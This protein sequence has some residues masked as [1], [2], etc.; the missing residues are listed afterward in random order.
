MADKGLYLAH[1]HTTFLN[2]SDSSIRKQ[3]DKF[4]IKT[5]NCWVFNKE[6]PLKLRD[7]NSLLYREHERQH[8]VQALSTPVGLYL[9]RCLLT[10][11]SCIQYILDV[12]HN[13]STVEIEDLPLTEWYLKGGIIIIE[14]A[15]LNEP[16]YAI[17]IN[18]LFGY[19]EVLTKFIQALEDGRCLSMKEFI[20]LANSANEEIKRA[21]DMPISY[22]WCSHTES[23][24]DYLPAGLFTITEIMEAGAR[25]KERSL[26]FQARNGQE[27]V[28]EWEASTIH[29]IYAPA[30][31]WLLESLDHPDAAALAIDLSL[32]TPI[33]LC[34]VSLLDGKLYVEDCHPGWR[35]PR[36][37]KAMQN[38]FWRSDG[39]ENLN[40]M[41]SEVMLKAGLGSVRSIAMH[42]QSAPFNGPNSWGADGRARGL[43]EELRIDN[44]IQFIEQEL[45][46]NIGSRAVTPFSGAFSGVMG[47]PMI[48]FPIEFYSDTA[49]MNNTP[50]IAQFGNPKIAFKM[51]D[52]TIGNLSLLAMIQDGSVELIKNVENSFRK[53]LVNDYKL[54]W[55]KF[56]HLHAYEIARAHCGRFADL[57]EWE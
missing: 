6:I 18:R 10:L 35:L 31:R 28:R 2:V 29:G 49:T 39:P 22:E 53:M 32:M 26:L 52:Y 21:S 34:T 4:T 51:Y 9:W 43:P 8:H 44:Y 47:T 38:V 20:A 48:R 41:I 55:N 19:I 3:L 40:E 25:L 37:V 56:R 13:R 1:V 17:Y 24:E 15:F 16:R 50:R 54:K 45:R 7:I 23:A 57:L 12:L 42:I 11:I 36:I 46:E 14:K 5:G 30:Y 27:L 33:D